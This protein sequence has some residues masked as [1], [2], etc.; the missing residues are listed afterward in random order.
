M[1]LFFAQ[2]LSLHKNKLTVLV[3]PQGNQLLRHS[4]KMPPILLVLWRLHTLVNA[5]YSVVYQATGRPFFA[6]RPL[7]TPSTCEPFSRAERVGKGRRTK[8]S[9]A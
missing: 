8:K 3:A 6:R 7:P 1:L 9:L 4:W 5:F 2:F